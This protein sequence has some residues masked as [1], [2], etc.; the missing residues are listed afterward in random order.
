M[1]KP[2]RMLVR[3]R[4]TFGGSGQQNIHAAVVGMVNPLQGQTSDHDPRGGV[5]GYGAQKVVYSA[6]L[7]GDLA[8]E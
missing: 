6:A 3:D 8:D 1:R 4:V 2:L 5:V 7:P